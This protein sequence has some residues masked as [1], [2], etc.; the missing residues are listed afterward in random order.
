MPSCFACRV[1]ARLTHMQINFGTQTLSCALASL[2]ARN[3]WPKRALTARFRSLTPPNSPISGP[4]L[5]ARDGS[6]LQGILVRHPMR[7]LS[8][9]HHT[10]LDV[11]ANPGRHSGRT[12]R[13]RPP[14][15]R[16]NLLH[17]YDRQSTR[18]TSKH[19]AQASVWLL[20]D[21]YTTS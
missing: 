21:R 8:S 5:S 10:D 20:P 19:E 4:R 1:G 15:C 3:R 13:T 11:S 14:P 18:D 6:S 7:H 12:T 9:W 2:K 17:R 16:Q